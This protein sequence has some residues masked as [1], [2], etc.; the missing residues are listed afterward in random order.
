MIEDFDEIGNIHYFITVNFNDKI[1]NHDTNLKRKLEKK[2]KKFV[3]LINKN[4]QL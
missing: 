1:K 4:V 3:N 2:S